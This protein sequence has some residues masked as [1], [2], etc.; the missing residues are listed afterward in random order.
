MSFALSLSEEE[1]ELE[2]R[3]IDA[4]MVS[5]SVSIPARQVRGWM[6]FCQRHKLEGISF[7]DPL[8]RKV[9]EWFQTRYG[10]RLNVDFDFGLAV[11]MIRGDLFRFRCPLFY[12]RLLT[13][14]APE[15]LNHR[16]VGV[17]VNK[18]AMLNV[19]ELMEGITVPYAR[20]LTDEDLAE[21]HDRIV[22]TQIRFGRISDAGAQKFIEE[23]RADIRVAVDQMMRNVPQCGPSKWASL[24][25]VEKF[26]KA[27]ITQQGATFKY[28]HDLAELATAAENVGL[29]KLNREAINLVQCSASVR[30]DSALV[31]TTGAIK[32]HHAAVFVCAT[33]SIHLSGRSGW[34]TGALGRGVLG[35]EGQ[36]KTLPM[37]LIAR[38]REVLPPSGDFDAEAFKF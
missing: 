26:L 34:N 1:L 15:L 30:Y 37:I 9:I 18:P 7:N 31:D 21:L 35:F 10:N 3:R 6:L 12:G 16:S 25:A 19:L 17:A 2:M 22:R 4:L 5:Q 28:N 23:G 13:A 29:P 11:L 20:S 33:V 14:C 27:Y 32:A 8:S 36:Q 24:Q 38:S